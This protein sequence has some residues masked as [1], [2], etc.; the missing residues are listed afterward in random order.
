MAFAEGQKLDAYATFD[1]LSKLT[2]DF[3]RQLKI[4]GGFLNDLASASDPK[5]FVYAFDGTAFPNVPAA[6]AAAQLRRGMDL[7]QR[8]Q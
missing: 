3:K 1:E 2:P 8:Q 7:H 5:A 6:A 4:T